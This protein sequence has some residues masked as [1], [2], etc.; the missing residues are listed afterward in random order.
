[1]D[2]LLSAAAGLSGNLHGNDSPPGNPRERNV[3]LGISAEAQ[4]RHGVFM[5]AI[6]Q[7]CWG[8]LVRSVRH[9]AQTALRQWKGIVAE[10]IVYRGRNFHHNVCFCDQLCL[11]LCQSCGDGSQSSCQLFAEFG[12][13]SFFNR[14]PFLRTEVSCGSAKPMEISSCCLYC[15]IV[16]FR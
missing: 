5:E 14:Q 6:V 3:N 2:S 16:R 7:G 10:A 11:A 12:G 4:V 1:M 13:T 9:L 8:Q 15:S